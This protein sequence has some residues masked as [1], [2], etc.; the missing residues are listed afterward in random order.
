MTVTQWRRDDNGTFWGVGETCPT[1]PPGIYDPV[2]VPNAGLAWCPVEARDDMLLRFPGSDGARVVEEIELFWTQEEAFARYSLPFKRGILLHGPPGSGK[3]ST[4]RLV[5][6]S[7]VERGGY[8][9]LFSRPTT[10]VTAVRMLRSAHPEASVVV[11]MEDLDAI[12]HNGDES[13]VLNLLDGAEQVHRVV[14]LATTNYPELL[15]DRIANRPSRFDRRVL[16]APPTAETRRM[17]LDTLVCEGDDFDLDRYV[18][19]TADMSLA[20]V[21]ELFVATAILGADYDLTL[22]ELRSMSTRA[23]STDGTGSSKQAGGIYV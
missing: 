18:K 2:Q 16:I 20:H 12:L 15:K 14:F 10:L 21:K 8:V 4:L 5:A 11:L 17:Y 7:V 9:L 23:H 22:K 6:E 19:D 1:L 13:S 3:S